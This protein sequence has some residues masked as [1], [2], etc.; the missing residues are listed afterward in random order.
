[1]RHGY[2]RLISEKYDGMRKEKKFD[3]RRN[4]ESSSEYDCGSVIGRPR[5]AFIDLM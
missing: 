3:E 5:M 1:M 2:Q 4:Y